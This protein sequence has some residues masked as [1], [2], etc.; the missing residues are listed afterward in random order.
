MLYPVVFL[1]QLK[2]YVTYDVKKV[3]VQSEFTAKDLFE[4]T[5]GDEVLQKYLNRKLD[6]NKAE[7]EELLEKSPFTPKT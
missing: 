4:S 2:P 1:L 5:Y 3:I 7:P 6:I